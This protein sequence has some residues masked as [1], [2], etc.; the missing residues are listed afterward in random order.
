MCKYR[1]LPPHPLAARPLVSRRPP[2]SLALALI[3]A[4]PFLARPQVGQTRD[5]RGPYPAV[6][7][8]TG[9]NFRGGRGKKAFLLRV[10]VCVEVFFC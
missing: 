8:R 1:L 10:C 6:G 7:V 4:L 9:S 3:S 2:P 5:T